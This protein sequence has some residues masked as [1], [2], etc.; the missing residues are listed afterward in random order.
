MGQKTLYPLHGI[1]TVLNTPFN[2]EGAIDLTA[3]QRHAE[4]ALK[5]GV[6]GFLVPG[7]A[8]EA[9]R[10]THAEKLKMVD[11]VMKVA[12]GQVPVIAGTMGGNPD[13]AKKLIKDYLIMGCKNVLVN[14]PYTNR[15]TYLAQVEELAGAGPEMIMLQDWD[16]QGYGLPDELIVELFQTVEAFRCLKIETVPA[17]FKYS[18]ILELTNHKLN[19]S[20]GWAVT[21]MTEGLQRGVHAF[22]PTAMHSIYV[23]IYQL[24]NSGNKS[25][26]EELFLR[27]LPVIAF[28]NQHLDVSIRFFKRLLWRQGIYP[29]PDVRGVRI[30]FDAIH[31]AIADR[32]IDRVLQLE[33]QLRAM[34]PS[35]NATLPPK[36]AGG[37]LL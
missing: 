26:A 14:L 33:E 11:T 37:A 22:M 18:K 23:A 1:V 21:Q 10:L 15:E 4:L 20:G 32:Q 5:A 13:E 9:D 7:M 24:W 6:G 25:E 3:L 8:A 19:I 28:S 31:I 12:G 2:K 17:G 36:Q 30:P 35:R 34:E 29:T 16:S 27:I